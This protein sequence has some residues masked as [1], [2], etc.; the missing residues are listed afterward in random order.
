MSY[1]SHSAKTFQLLAGL[2]FKLCL[3]RK[4][5][6][7]Y[8]SRHVTNIIII[9]LFGKLSITNNHLKSSHTYHQNRNK[10]SHWMCVNYLKDAPWTLGRHWSYLVLS[11]F[12]SWPKHGKYLS[13]ITKIMKK[14]HPKTPYVTRLYQYLIL[15]ETVVALFTF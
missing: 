15:S 7:M 3:H 1:L 12:F 14:K 10:N 11:D 4:C 8:Y 13:H 9:I 5:N 2:H 6:N